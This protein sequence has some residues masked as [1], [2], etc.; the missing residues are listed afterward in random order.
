M[1]LVAAFIVVSLIIVLRKRTSKAELKQN[2]PS[3]DNFHNPSYT[4]R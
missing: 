1:L 3:R 4:G 2:S